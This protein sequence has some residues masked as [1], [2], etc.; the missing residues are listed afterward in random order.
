MRAYVFPHLIALLNQ[1]PWKAFPKAP[2]ISAGKR[3]WVAFLYK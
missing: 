1:N 2:L 3:A